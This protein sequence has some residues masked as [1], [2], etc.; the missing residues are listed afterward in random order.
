MSS[1]LVECHSGYTYGERPIALLWQGVR[2]VIQV[3]EARWRIPGG[4][5]FRLVLIFSGSHVL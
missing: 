2:L 3:I 1:E 4:T 5:C